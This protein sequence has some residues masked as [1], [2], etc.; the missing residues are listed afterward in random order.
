ML[1][2]IVDLEYFNIVLKVY[3][4]ELNSK[5]LDIKEIF[6]YLFSGQ[7]EMFYIFFVIDVGVWLS[8]IFIDYSS[9]SIE[10]LQVVFSLKLFNFLI[11]IFIFVKLGYL[12][13][14]FECSFVIVF[15]V[16][17]IISFV[18]FSVVFVCGLCLIL[19][20]VDKFYIVIF[21]SYNLIC[22][23]IFLISL[24]MGGM[25]LCYVVSIMQFMIKWVYYY[26]LCVFSKLVV[27]NNVELMNK[28]QG[29]VL[30]YY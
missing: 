16:E 4:N 30:C 13:S 3:I 23:E 5:F 12:L 6:C 22:K 26:C 7:S 25:L 11:W 27:K 17:F 24:L 2:C 14:E 15:G 28:V 1:I 19:F 9:V 20:F 10:V 21:D 18:G 29:M 8:I